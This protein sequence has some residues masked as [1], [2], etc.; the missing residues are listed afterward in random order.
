MHLYK[1]GETFCLYTT[2]VHGPLVKTKDV[3][4]YLEICE[5]NQNEIV[6]IKRSDFE[7][8]LKCA[9]EGRLADYLVQVLDMYSLPSSEAGYG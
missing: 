8:I 2:F 4:N 7:S 3:I 6:V 9:K 5:N 1:D